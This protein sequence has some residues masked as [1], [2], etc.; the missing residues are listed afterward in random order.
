[1]RSNGEASDPDGGFI[2]Q[3][4]IYASDREFMDVVQPFVEDGLSSQEPTLVAVQERHIENL[5]SELGGAPD[6]VTLH[7]VE[8]WYETSART[9]E[10]FARWAAERTEERRRVRLVGEPPWALGHEAQLRDWARHESVINVA[11]AGRPV[12]FICPYD[13]RALPNEVL[14]HARGTHPEIVDGGRTR[15]S[16]AYENPL[17]FCARLDT[18]IDAQTGE[19]AIE[20]EF[21]LDDLPTIRRV[22]GSFA[23]DAGLDVPRTEE[24]VL[25]VNEI[26]TNAVIHGRP[27][28]IL[29]LWPTDGEVVVEVTDTGDGIRD[30]LAGQLTPPA[31]SQGGRGLWMARQLCD[32]VEVSCSETGCT[33]TMHAATGNRAG[34]LTPV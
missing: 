8:D 5:R 23:I 29:R 15:P 24:F 4:L 16:G 27:P 2:H 18:A 3:A 13:A 19:P 30:I 11:F 6:G 32:A 1:M 9:R 21:I 33:V 28:A 22:V 34:S 14:A 12:T 10:K 20:L 25:A 31:V 17:D 26:T 7:P